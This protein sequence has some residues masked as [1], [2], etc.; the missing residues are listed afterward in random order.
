MK[1]NGEEYKTIWFQNNIV[2]IIVDYNV[3]GKQRYTALE[4]LL[5]I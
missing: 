4:K 5:P 3:I 1:I 2:K